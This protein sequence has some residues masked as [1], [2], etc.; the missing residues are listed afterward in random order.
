MAKATI[1]INLKQW[2]LVYLKHPKDPQAFRKSFLFYELAEEAVRRHFPH[3]AFVEIVSG[4]TLL[5]EGIR[6]LPS[7]SNIWGISITKY[8]FGE[9]LTRR[10]KGSLRLKYRRQRRRNKI[11]EVFDGPLILSWREVVSRELGKPIS[12]IPKKELERILKRKTKIFY[13]E[14]DDL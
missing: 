1:K 4:K 5:D 12:D 2:Y 6:V 11:R 13:R 10:Q 3:L 7:A 9:N 8:D 14:F